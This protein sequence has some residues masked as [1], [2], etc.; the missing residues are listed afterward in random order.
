MKKILFVS[1][2]LFLLTGCG[3]NSITCS[4]KQE[5]NGFVSNT[6]TKVNFKNNKISSYTITSDIDVP[7]EYSS[8]MDLLLEKGKEPYLQYEKLSGTTL[9]SNSSKNK[10]HI[11]LN[12]NAS[13]IKESDKE[14]LNELLDLSANYKTIKNSFEKAK[15]ECK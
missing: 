1:V 8:S 4:L 12:V 10:I 6:S 13:K 11:E 9:K 3:K 15:Y 7:D 14:K 2:M 5:E